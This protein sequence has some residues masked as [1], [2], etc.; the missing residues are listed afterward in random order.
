MFDRVCKVTLTFESVDEILWCY[1]SN[2]SSLP[3]LSQDA[4]CLSKLWKMKFWNL[5]EICLWSHLAVKGLIAIV[6]DVIIGPGK[7]VTISTENCKRITPFSISNAR[8]QDWYRAHGNLN[9]GSTERHVSFCLLVPKH[10]SRSPLQKG[11]NWN[12]V[13]KKRMHRV[14]VRFTI[15]LYSKQNIQ[16]RLPHLEML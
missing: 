10:C 14:R 12:Q 15:W 1:Y 3:V 9:S 4:I 8:I 11:I 13:E 6:I 16:C 2:E 7:I 5:L